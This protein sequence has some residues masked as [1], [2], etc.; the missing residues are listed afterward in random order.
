[1]LP[2]RSPHHAAPRA[3][4]IR[5][6]AVRARP[7]DPPA[8]ARAR[9]EARPPPPSCR[10]REPEE[11]EA[12]RQPRAVQEVV[13]APQREHGQAQEKGDDPHEC[14]SQPPARAAWMVYLREPGVEHR[15]VPARHM[16][17][18]VTGQILAP[19]SFQNE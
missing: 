17:A 1:A 2:R 18:L 13:Q 19:Y 12:E 14:A 11:D 16:G 7:P 4:V 10:C 6:I 8:A 9:E 5:A 3:G 15:V